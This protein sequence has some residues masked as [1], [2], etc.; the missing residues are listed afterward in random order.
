MVHISKLHTPSIVIGVLLQKMQDTNVVAVA[1]NYCTCVCVLF[2]NELTPRTKK[3]EIM[4][5]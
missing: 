5:R 4:G 3:F 1:T 2:F